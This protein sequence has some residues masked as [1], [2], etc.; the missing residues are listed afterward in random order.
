MSHTIDVDIKL[1][2]TDWLFTQQKASANGNDFLELINTLDESKNQALFTTSFV[3]A[4]LE[5]IYIQRGNVY[6][7]VFLPFMLQSAACFIYFSFYLQ[8]EE[9]EFSVSGILLQKCILV[10]TIYFVYLEGLQ[11]LDQGPYDYLW[12]L[13]NIIDLTSS[14]LNWVLVVNEWVNHFF[15]DS[16]SLKVCTMLALVCVWYKL[17]YWLRLFKDPA[18][19]MNLLIKT[20]KDIKAFMVMMSI[21]VALFTNILFIFN[22]VDES[23]SEE[24]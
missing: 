19:F 2:R 9:P 12:D 15:L 13:N 23:L 3:D 4:L 5:T 11:M 20:L 21:L 14:V 8:H 6:N 7:Y 16:K 10:L 24:E 18:F 22:L 17:F 1:I